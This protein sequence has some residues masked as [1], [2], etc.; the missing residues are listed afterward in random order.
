[1]KNKDLCLDSEGYLS[2]K[3]YINLDNSKAIREKQ[4][5]F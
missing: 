1:L 3:K 5:I 4:K 2:G